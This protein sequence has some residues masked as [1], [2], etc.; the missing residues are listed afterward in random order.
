[1][2]DD[3]SLFT[4]SRIKHFIGFK[5]E[6]MEKCQSFVKTKSWSDKV[7]GKRSAE[8][9]FDEDCETEENVLLTWNFTW[10][11]TWDST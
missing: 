5:L 6:A 11:C 3:M 8:E 7:T 2:P 4:I 9:A 10:D 1:M